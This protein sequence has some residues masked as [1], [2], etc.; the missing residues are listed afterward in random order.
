MQGFLKT[1]QGFFGPVE[2]CQGKPFQVKD[3]RI[4]RLDFKG[5]LIGFQSSLKLFKGGESKPFLLPGIGISGIKLQDFVKG[6]QGF[7]GFSGFQQCEPPVE[8]GPGVLRLFVQNFVEDVDSFFVP[9]MLKKVKAFSKGFLLTDNNS[10]DPFFIF[11]FLQ[12]Q[13]Q[14][15]NPGLK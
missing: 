14:G 12:T 13:K 8:K 4:S 1:E 7:S 5:M 9:F 3:F 15:T 11:Y 6:V 10:S 2:F